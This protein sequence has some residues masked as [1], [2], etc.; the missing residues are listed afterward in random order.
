MIFDLGVY[1]AVLGM[2]SMAVN[3]LGGYLRPGMEYEDFEFHPGGFAVGCPDAGGGGW[4]RSMSRR[5]NPG[6]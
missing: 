4:M 6:A 2:L 5:G 1:L 3:V